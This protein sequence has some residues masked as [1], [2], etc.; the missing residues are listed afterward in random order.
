[1]KMAPTRQRTESGPFEAGTA[2]YGCLSRERSYQSRV[3][4]WLRRGNV[5]NPGS[6]KTPPANR[7]AGGCQHAGGFVKI[8]SGLAIH[9]APQTCFDTAARDERGAALVCICERSSRPVF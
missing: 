3:D 6:D 4:G 8:I 7:R 2:L 9:Q 5:G 1:M